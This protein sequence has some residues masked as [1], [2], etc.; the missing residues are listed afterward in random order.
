MLVGFVR[1]NA[2]YI[3]GAAHYKDR[4]TER[5]FTFAQAKDA[6]ASGKPVEVN[7]E[8]VDVR[9]LFRRASGPNAGTCAVVSLLTLDI[10]TVYYNAPDD[11]HTTLN[12]NLYRWPVN[13]VDLVKAAIDYRKAVK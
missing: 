3:T 10:I 12:H 2:A 13:V 8:G 6:I 1:A 4:A 5:H 9:A 11:T 7:K